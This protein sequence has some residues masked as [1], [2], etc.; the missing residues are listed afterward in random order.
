MTPRI[1]SCR[2]AFLTIIAL[3]QGNL[4]IVGIIKD[5]AAWVLRLRVII[6]GGR[7]VLHRVGH[8]GAK[9]VAVA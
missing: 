6:L 8:G 9:M 5:G 2:D 3:G 7:G 4:V 1:L